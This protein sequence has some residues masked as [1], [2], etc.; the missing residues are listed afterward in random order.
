[1]IDYQM[2]TVRATARQ[3]Q[4][5]R[6]I[7]AL[8]THISNPNLILYPDAVYTPHLLVHMNLLPFRAYHSPRNRPEREKNISLSFCSLV[9]L[10]LSLPLSIPFALTPS[11]RSVFPQVNC[12]YTQIVARLDSICASLSLFSFISVSISLSP[13]AYV[14]TRLAYLTAA[15]AFTLYRVV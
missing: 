4:A 2:E 7:T 15:L 10:P 9:C 14:R 6:P 3:A 1:M 5:E 12:N 13:Y 8:Y 11:V